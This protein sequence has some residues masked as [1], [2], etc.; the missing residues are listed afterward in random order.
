M[1]VTIE[2]E[3]GWGE[4]QVAASRLIYIHNKA[5]QIDQKQS[6]RTAICDYF[7]YSVSRFVNLAWMESA[8]FTGGSFAQVSLLAPKNGVNLNVTSGIQ[9]IEDCEKSVVWLLGVF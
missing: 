3:G 8:D 2:N 5:R 6:F 7:V 4:A 1:L 9:P